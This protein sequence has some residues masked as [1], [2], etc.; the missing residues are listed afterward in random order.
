MRLTRWT[1]F[2]TFV[3]VAKEQNAGK[4]PPGIKHDW[5]L[6]QIHPFVLIDCQHPLL[7]FMNSC[8]CGLSMEELRDRLTQFTPEGALGSAFNAGCNHFFYILDE[9][10]VAGQTH[11]NAFANANGL[12]PRPVLRPIIRAWASTASE[13]IRFIVSGT[14]FSLSLFR[15]VLTSGVGKTDPPWDVVHEIGDF[16]TPE[17]QRLY[18]SRYLPPTFLSSMSGSAH[19]KNVRVATRTVMRNNPSCTKQS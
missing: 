7:A 12:D 4:L 16:T 3:E 13:P 1:I 19:L 14:G 18:I 6:F 2:H 15:E 9:A 5:L 8:L 17:L 11:L 10:Q